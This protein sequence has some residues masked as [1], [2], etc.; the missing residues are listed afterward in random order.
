[1]ELKYSA[2]IE[3]LVKESGEMAMRISDHSNIL[4]TVL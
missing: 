1:M 2:K 4:L 3:E